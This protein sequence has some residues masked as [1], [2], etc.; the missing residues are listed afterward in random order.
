[1]K[2]SKKSSGKYYQDNKERLQ[3]KACESKKN[4]KE[5]TIWLWTIKKSIKEWKAKTGWV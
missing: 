2:M 5:T 3:E 1:M 4:I